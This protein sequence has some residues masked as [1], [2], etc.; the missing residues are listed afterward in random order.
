MGFFGSSRAEIDSQMR[1]A[2]VHLLA[3]G[4]TALTRVLAMEGPSPL[5]LALGGGELFFTEYFIY[6]TDSRL[7]L[8]QV[9]QLSDKPKLDKAYALDRNDLILVRMKRVGSWISMWVRGSH[10]RRP[11]RLN[12]NSLWETEGRR[13]GELLSARGPEA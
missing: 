2:A 12:I 9:S 3:P 7:L 10:Q 11:L 13:L 6:L 8:V 4:E 5:L 1:D